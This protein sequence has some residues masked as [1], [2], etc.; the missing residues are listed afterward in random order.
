MEE[1]KTIAQWLYDKIL[2]EGHVDQETAVQ[3]IREKFGEQY[4]YETE[5]GGEAI[6]AAVLRQF[7][8]LNKDKT[9]DW[10]NSDHSW[11]ARRD[12]DGA[13]L[14]SQRMPGTKSDYVELTNFNMEPMDF[15]VE[16]IDLDVEPV[17]F[18]GLI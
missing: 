5:S 13:A 1:R 17:D 9:I 14:P 12:S 18:D 10:E 7:R 6:D 2:S 15:Q 11:Y 4:T 8:K 16:P 3:E